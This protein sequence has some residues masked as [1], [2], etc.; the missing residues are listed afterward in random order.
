MANTS[1]HFEVDEREMRSILA[2]LRLL[3]WTLEPKSL[4]TKAQTKLDLNRLRAVRRLAADGGH[5]VPLND[6]EV[7][8]LYERVASSFI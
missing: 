7:Y 4:L 6:K 5:V 8:A 2:G 3:Q 1:Y